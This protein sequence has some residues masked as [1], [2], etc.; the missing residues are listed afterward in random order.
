MESAETLIVTL[1]GAT[2]EVLSVLERDS[3][4]PNSAGPMYSPLHRHSDSTPVLRLGAGSNDLPEE[5]WQKMEQ[6][7]R[8]LDKDLDHSEEQMLLLTLRSCAKMHDS[9][10][11]G[12]LEGTLSL[13]LALS[14]SLV[15]L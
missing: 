2:N 8:D 3:H 5:T 10:R 12:S 7:D 15:P 9:A 6:R 4:S 14:E 13:S 1:K 11:A